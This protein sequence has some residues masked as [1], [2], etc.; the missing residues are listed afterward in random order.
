MIFLLK[1]WLILIGIVIIIFGSYTG[2]YYY[3]S[4]KPTPIFK[5]KIFP[6]ATLV[7]PFYNEEIVMKKKIEDISKISYPKNKLLVLFLNDH[8]DDNSINIIKKESKIL[9]FKFKIVNN[10][11]KRGKSNALNYIFPKIKSEITIITDA[12][13]LIKEDAVENLVQYFQNKTIGGANAKLVILKPGQ[14]SKTY[15]EEKDYRFFY[16]IWRHG[17][18]N[19]S[20][21]SICNGPLMAFRS[22]L[23]EEIRLGSV[24]D[25]TELVFK[26]INKNFRVVYDST[27][28]VYEVTPLESVERT[29][30]KMRRVRG[31]IEVY[32]K[33]LG[34]LGK[35]KFGSI[36]YPYALLTH[37]VAPYLIL[38][39]SLIYLILIIKIPLIILLLLGFFIPKIG[40]FAYSFISTQI[41]MALSPFLARGWNTAKSS[42]EE[43]GR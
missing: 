16:D 17:E 2:L 3:F 15:K 38:A 41:I 22:K 6:T 14:D 12:D 1:L 19:I 30:Q 10:E 33:N 26:V 7:I 9:P 32:L 4:K 28:L 5:K 43:L 8:S 29:K 37:V 23:L 39:I 11:N 42:R 40:P 35:G 13:S 20:S 31:L 18:S 24:V 36:V 25:D 34:M 27:S 21:I